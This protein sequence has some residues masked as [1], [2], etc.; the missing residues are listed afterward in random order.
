MHNGI[1]HWMIDTEPWWSI[2]RCNNDRLRQWGINWSGIPTKSTRSISLRTISLWEGDIFLSF[3][4][5]GFSV[6]SSKWWVADTVGSLRS[7]NELAITS[8]WSLMIFLTASASFEFRCESS[9]SPNWSSFLLF[10]FLQ[11]QN[12]LFYLVL[13]LLFIFIRD[14][15]CELIF[16]TI[17]FVP[18][19]LTV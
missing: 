9:S 4:H 12:Q 3:W 19:V 11:Q 17:T 8:G 14:I 16:R 10:R 2:Y 5:I 1:Q 13:Y 7:S 18:F 15:F 6:I